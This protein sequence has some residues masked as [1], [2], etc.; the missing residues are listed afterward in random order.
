MVEPAARG[1]LPALQLATDS[2]RLPNSTQVAFLDI[3]NYDI[4]A[5]IG[6]KVRQHNGTTGAR[7]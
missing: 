1:W 2:F 7:R 6:E 5:Q 4:L 3:H